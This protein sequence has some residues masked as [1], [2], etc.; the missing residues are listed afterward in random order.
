MSSSTNLS[1]KAVRVPKA[2][3]SSIMNVETLPA[4]SFPDKGQILVQVH[5]IGINPV[6]TYI[7]SGNYAT[8]PSYPYTPGGC[9]SGIVVSVGKDV[10]KF[11]TGDRIYSARTISGAYAENALIDESY[12]WH[13]PNSISFAEGAALGVPFH[14]AYR[15]IFSKAKLKST[16]SIL[17]HGA[18]GGVGI[19]CLQMA[20]SIGCQLIL[21]SAG[22]SI[23]I[24]AITPFCDHVIS[25]GDIDG[26]LSLTKNKG[27]DVIIEMASHKNL[28]NDLQMLASNGT[29]VIVGSRGPVEVNPR[30]VMAREA[31]IT[32]VMLWLAN[33][34]E[35]EEAANFIEQG[36][37]S[38]R[39]KPI[40]GHLYKGLEKASEAHDE[41][42]SHTK[43]T[44][45]KIVIQIREEKEEN[46]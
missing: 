42:I 8:I 18:S 38:K 19:A 13:L 33:E 24:D 11:K 1:Y 21:G 22:S 15:S 10:T 35:F 7:R 9:C 40:I 31:T 25:H 28:G 41:V 37:L 4:L 39:L 2:G 20:K 5:C 16:Q 27:V 3:P 30:D 6:E 26:V 44:V 29:I 45:G 14:T 12:A 23:G 17:I 34:Q 46:V 32:G 36:L 43:G